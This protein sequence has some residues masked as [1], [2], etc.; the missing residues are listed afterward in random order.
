MSDKSPAQ[1]AWSENT[2]IV[3]ADYIDHVAFNLIVNFERMLMRKIPNADLSRWL[4]GIAL[5][6]GM[7]PVEPEKLSGEQCPEVHVVLIH[8]KGS[9]ALDNFLPA[10]YEKELNAKAFKDTLGE[11]I[12]TT[13]AVENL[14]NK[15]DLFLE[16]ARTVVQQKEVKRIMLVPNADE[17]D[18]YGRLR[19]TL[20]GV[21]D[22]KR[23]T[24]FAM[25]PMPGGNFRQ[26]I[27]GYSLMNA[28]GIRADELH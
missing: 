23:I 16:I 21:D 27:L 24:L 25:Q 1:K 12:I 5:D 18:I 15:D 6:G 17:G 26:E 8:N 7:R 2:I 3:D 4:D 20:R 28:L 19:Q 22:N 11:F 9:E 10:N 13:I 14:T